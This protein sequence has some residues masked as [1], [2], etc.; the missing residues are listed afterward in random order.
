MITRTAMLIATFLLAMPFVPVHGT[1]TAHV[2]IVTGSA[3]IGG[4]LSASVM[5][6]GASDLVGYDI[7]VVVNPNVLTAT[8]ASLGGTLLDPATNNV[9]IARQDVFPSVGIVRYALVLLGGGSV[10]PSGS[11]SLLNMNFMVNDPASTPDATADQYPSAISLTSGL[12][13]LSGGSI[14]TVPTDDTGASY[15]PPADSGLRSVGCRAANGGFNTLAKGLDDPI[16]CRDTNTGGQSITVASAFS[17]RSLGGVTGSTMSAP[18]TL[19]AGQNGEQDAVLTVPNANDIFIV[20][21]TP[22]RLIT[23]NDGSVLAIPGPSDTFK[24]VVNVG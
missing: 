22:T 12:V 4:S 2:S 24:V 7:K 5:V 1:P 11:A 13:G 3:D 14:V 17:W 9:L 8:G 19:A 18:Q 6:S 20:T 15:M 23:F 16:F 10:S 21:G